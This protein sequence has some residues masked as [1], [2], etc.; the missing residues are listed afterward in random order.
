MKGLK[1]IT[2]CSHCENKEQFGFGYHGLELDGKMFLL[3]KKCWGELLVQVL[4]YLW[5]TEIK[6]R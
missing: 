6:V 3:C 1:E 2:P 5:R 4:D